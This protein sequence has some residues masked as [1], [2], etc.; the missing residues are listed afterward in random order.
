MKLIDDTRTIMAQRVE[1][2]KESAR[3]TPQ[4]FTAV[5]P[6]GVWSKVFSR[7]LIAVA[8]LGPLVELARHYG[9]VTVGADNG[10]LFPS[11]LFAI[12][13]FVGWYLENQRQAK[14]ATGVIVNAGVSFIVAVR[15]GRRATDPMVAVPIDPPSVEQSTIEKPRLDYARDRRKAQRD[16]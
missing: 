15:G 6:R 14:D 13:G 10:H 5:K 11:I 3:L 12:A 7:F 9:L 8:I 16:E 4:S 2:Q 1:S